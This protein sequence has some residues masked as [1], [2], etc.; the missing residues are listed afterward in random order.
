MAR[1]FYYGTDFQVYASSRSFSQK[2]SADPGAFRIESRTV[3][4]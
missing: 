1:S 4:G 3:R 2:I